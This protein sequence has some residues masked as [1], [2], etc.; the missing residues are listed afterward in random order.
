MAAPHKDNKIYRSDC[1]VKAACL[2][3][4]VGGFLYRA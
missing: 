1:N 3:I 4:K 2:E